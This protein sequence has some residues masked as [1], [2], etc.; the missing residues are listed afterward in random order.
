MLPCRQ[1]S[2]CV[3]LMSG[4]V[5]LDSTAPQ[6]FQSG[7]ERRGWTN[8]NEDTQKNKGKFSRASSASAAMA[9]VYFKTLFWWRDRLI[10]VDEE[11]VMTRRRE[12]SLQSCWVYMKLRL[13]TDYLRCYEA[14][15]KLKHLSWSGRL[16]MAKSSV[17]FWNIIW[18]V[19]LYWE[20]FQNSQII[21]S[22]EQCLPYHIP[23]ITESFQL[24]DYIC[25][26]NP[27]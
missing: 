2:L 25:G 26:N 5:A 7:W 6:G 8:W 18:F 17:E 15:L 24:L 3:V 12:K 10:I 4:C 23:S 14:Y 11:R 20:F 19:A 13:L 21:C 1:V 27:M 9:R 22:L 16:L